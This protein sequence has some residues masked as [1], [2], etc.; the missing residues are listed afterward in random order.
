[1]LIAQRAKGTPRQAIDNILYT[2]GS[3]AKSDDRDVITIEDACQAF[4]RHHIDDEG[5]DK[6]DRSYLEVL[7]EQYMTPLSVISAKLESTPLTVQRVVEPYLIKAGF[8]TKGRSSHR[9]ITEKGIQHMTN[10]S[11]KS[12]L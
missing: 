1:M 5:L 11:S 10:T 3:V 6:R 12:G 8:V 4:D 2:C 9:M 7:L